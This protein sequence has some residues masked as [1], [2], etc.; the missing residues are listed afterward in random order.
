M[1]FASPPPLVFWNR[2]WLAHGNEVGRAQWKLVGR[3]QPT[4]RIAPDNMHNPIVRRAI[5]GDPRLRKFLYWS[6]LPV[7]SV[8]RKDCAAT[9]TIA[10]ARYGLPARNKARLYRNSA[11]DLCAA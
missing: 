7:A 8:E 1:I 2:T 9:V 10:D 6:V 3:L 11:I 5:A 4:E